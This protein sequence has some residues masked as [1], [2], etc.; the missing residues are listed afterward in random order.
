MNYAQ[1]RDSEHLRQLAEDIKTFA[2]D[3]LS[4]VPAGACPR[5]TVFFFPGGMA[6]R[7]LRAVQP[8]QDGAD[9]SGTQYEDV[10]IAP[11]TFIGAWRSLKMHKGGSGCFRD[12]DDRIII[13]NGAVEFLGV[14]PHDGFIR[15]CRQH[16]ADLFIF[17]WDWRRRLD[18]TVA[19]FLDKFLPHFREAVMAAGCPDPLSRFSL[20][21]H[22]FGGMIVNLVLR[23]EHSI[24]SN[25]A[26]AITVATP[27]YGYPGQLHRWYEGEP[28]LMQ[29][30]LMAI[31]EVEQLDPFDL[32]D[33]S[34]MRKAVRQDMLEVISSMP[35]LYTLHFLDTVTHL[36][37]VQAPL[38]N[39]AE[40]FSLPSYPSLDAA[41]L[42]PADAYN[43]TANGS[44]VRFP[45][46]TGF[47]LLELN[48]GRAQFQQMA[49]PLPA[50]LAAKF[51]N[52]RGVTTE[53][54]APL[55]NTAAAVHW[56]WISPSF[57]AAGPSPVVD[58]GWV[59]GDDTQ[60]AWSTRLASN[61]ANCVTVPADGLEHACMMDNDTVLS[62]IEAIL[63]AAPPPP[64]PPPQNM[65]EQLITSIQ[66]CLYPQPQQQQQ[67][68][69][70][71]QQ[72][73]LLQQGAPKEPTDEDI[74]AFLRWLYH[75]R[76]LLKKL[77]RTKD[78]RI[79]VFP[80]ELRDKIPAITRRIYKDLV[81]GP[82]RRPPKDT[83]K[84]AAP[85]PEKPRAPSEGEK[86]S[87]EPPGKRK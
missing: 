12:K 24:L 7:L 66:N 86:P 53:N 73:N 67:Q 49:A 51:R 3:Y 55:L 77:P 79:D 22:S 30:E 69:Q 36:D 38:M 2:Q 81:R 48:Y 61:Q 78:I 35:A 29:G 45:M 20:V 14:T 64:P 23:S 42:T 41:T 71:Q 17:G 18:E 31:D 28:I 80:E 54:G 32:L 39:D 57:D 5:Q 87:R 62:R 82:V 63:C 1:T 6:S 13:P 27:F 33:Y 25:L 83:D 44:L 76:E 16:N 26:H 19:F 75:N 47:D 72:Q 15:W 21:G 11:D 52:I 59:H 46:N 8:Y 70:Q 56:G 65:L 43:P 40:G 84:P 10:W 58:T 68:V 4:A 74:R 60:P 9:M 85:A 37:P 34:E 50:A